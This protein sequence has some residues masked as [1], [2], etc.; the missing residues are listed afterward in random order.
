[1]LYL[2][3]FVLLYLS[4]RRSEWNVQCVYGVTG[5]VSL[6]GS[7]RLLCLR[8]SPVPSAPSSASQATADRHTPGYRHQ[9]PAPFLHSHPQHRTLFG[10]TRSWTN[11]NPNH[12]VQF[13]STNAAAGRDR[14]D[15]TDHTSSTPNPETR[16]TLRS[17]TQPHAQNR[18]LQP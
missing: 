1:M 11:S 16:F 14:V 12:F 18:H 4:I 15:P 6:A 13:C 5:C 10:T 8:S 17:Q 9:Q 7:H 3:H 2:L